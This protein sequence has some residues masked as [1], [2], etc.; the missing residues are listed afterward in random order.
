MY[1]I[2][3]EAEE[4]FDK[5]MS[6]FK[7]EF[8]SAA[9]DEFSKL[10]DIFPEY[11]NV[12]YYIE[13]S[14]KNHSGHMVLLDSYIEDHFE[15]DA[16]ALA[17]EIV[18]ETPSSGIAPEITRHLAAGEYNLA[19]EKLLTA[20]TVVPDSR[21]LLLLLAA[22]YRKI[23]KYTEAEKTLKRALVASPNDFEILNNLANVYMNQ[24]RYKESESIL[25]ELQRIDPDNP[26]LHNNYGALK[27]QMNDL[28]EAMI[29]FRRAAMIKP[30]WKIPKRNMQNLVK[31]IEA[32]DMKISTLRREFITK[33]YPDIGTELIR[34][35]FLRGHYADAKSESLTL[36]KAIPELPLP[37][38]YI[39]KVNE[40]FLDL[41]GALE[42]YRTLVK[43]EGKSNNPAYI[44]AKTLYE[45]GFTEEALSEIKKIAK[46]ERDYSDA[47]LEIGIAYFEAGLFEEALQRFEEAASIKCYP[48]VSYWLGMAQLQ[49]GEKK[50]AEE[51]FK[52]ALKLNPEYAEAHFRLGQLTIQ[53]EGREE[54]AREHFQRAL[55][56]NLNATLAEA[57]K[58]YT[59]EKKE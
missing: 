37:W 7:S 21:P 47:R 10:K 26:K 45:Q 54:E 27:M 35:L 24:G 11:P 31:L 28:D 29:M 8:Y 55:S 38:F 33:G 43:L 52:N 16:K 2:P 15:E 9:K 44:N 5:A 4:L 20:E 42:A 40:K 46:P 22:T 50:D 13:A 3:K 53:Q 17:E 12:D 59:E 23:G 39:G 30:D 18:I 1:I 48:D 49:L 6:L 58:E 57:A 41:E 56:L 32:L 19:I 51:S 34:Y 36:S 14:A 25:K